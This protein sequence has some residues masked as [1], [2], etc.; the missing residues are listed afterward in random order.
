MTTNNGAKKVLFVCRGNAFRSILAEAYLKSK[1]LPDVEV[2]SAGT[3]ANEHYAQNTVTFD[4]LPRLLEQ[5]GIGSFMKANW[6]EQLT[7]GILDK[8]DLT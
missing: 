6:G 8:P 5:H 3:V 7:Q 2:T 4:D 1:Q